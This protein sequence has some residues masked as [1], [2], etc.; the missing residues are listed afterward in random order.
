M[1]TFDSRDKAFENKFALDEEMKFKIH[2]RA[3]KML[4]MWVGEQLGVEGNDI[5]AY[6]KEV[7]EA[8]L[9]E[10]GHEDMM[11]KLMADITSQNASITRAD[12]DREYKS[13]L[14]LAQEQLMQGQ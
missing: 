13:L 4:G 2:A 12:L 6:A 3:A 7:L 14:K 9:A 10:A 1:T 11:K 5:E 8:D